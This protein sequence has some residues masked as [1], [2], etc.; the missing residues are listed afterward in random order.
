MGSSL[1]LIC[2]GTGRDGTSSVAQMLRR[3][4]DAEAAGRPVMH[5]WQAVEL[6]RAFCLFRETSDDRYA[7]HI[8]RV[9]RHCDHH[10]IVGAGYAAVLPFFAE[11]CASEI[12]L[13]HLKRNDRAACVASL[14]ENC[15][16]FPTNFR[17]YSED[18]NAKGE[19]LAAFHLGDASRAEWESWP[20]EKRVGWYYDATHRLVENAKPLFSRYLPI[21]TERISDE[22]TRR[23]LALMIGTV[24][25]PP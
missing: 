11:I 13:I 3:A 23:E 7:E 17:H 6:Q 14:V 4:Y 12:G 5:K 9:I 1:R 15:R 24:E 21:A 22:Q 18:P 10:C 16:L 25:I 8:R 2:V 19:M 20:I